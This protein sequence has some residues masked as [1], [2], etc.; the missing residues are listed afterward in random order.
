MFVKICGLTNA[1]DVSAVAALRPNA[2][3]FVFWPGSPRR[4]DPAEVKKWT[5]HIPANVL[6]VGV[7]VDEDPT[8]INR[9]IARAGL[10]VV[11]LHGSEEKSAVSQVAGLCWKAVH[12]DKMTVEEADAYAVRGILIDQYNAAMPGGTGETADWA[13]A[14]D[15]VQ[16]TKHKVLLAG[17]LNSNNIKE[18][19]ERVK[20]WGIDVS[21]GVESE[22]G[23]KD[24]RRVED[25]IDQC[26]AVDE[27]T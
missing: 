7:F 19:I 5:E 2:L 25:F 3:G 9:I 24:L 14:A 12:L 27:T 17:G 11:Q 23:R 8:E 16:R 10:N 15:F 18:A 21:S 6:R 22:P 1:E 4:V 13:A 20:P 26:R